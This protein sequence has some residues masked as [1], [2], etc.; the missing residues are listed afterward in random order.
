MKITAQDEY[1]LR[2]LLRIAKEESQDGITIAQ[3]SQVEGISNSYAAKVTRSLRLAGLIDSTRGPKGGYALTR[4]P[5]NIYMHEVMRALDGPLF[6]SSFCQ[7]HTGSENIC[8]N[9]VNCSVRS[10]WRVVQAAVDNILSGITLRDLMG[11]ER[12]AENLLQHI[13]DRVAY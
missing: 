2:L 12:T 4:P 5:E 7:N 8:V 6:E 11:N 10:L 1:G 13:F 3:L 9:S